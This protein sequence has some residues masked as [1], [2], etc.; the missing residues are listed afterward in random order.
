MSVISQRGGREHGC[1]HL[2]RTRPPR[3]PCLA[4]EV[5]PS[6]VV[7]PAPGVARSSAGA[8]APCARTD[9]RIIG[10]RDATFAEYHY[11]EEILDG[12]ATIVQNLKLALS[13][14]DY[15][16]V[17]IADAWEAIADSYWA[18]FHGRA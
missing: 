17:K 5:R 16:P 1:A 10:G 3:H 7:Q 8:A 11:L 15:D 13:E 12:A 4:C 6:S 18:R 9:S 2:V 14:P